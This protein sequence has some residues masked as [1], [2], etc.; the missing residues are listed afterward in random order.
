MIFLLRNKPQKAQVILVL[1]DA[2]IVL[3]GLVSSYNVRIYLFNEGSGLLETLL[4]KISFNFVVVILAHM[5]AF[6]I[7]ELYDT[8]RPFT[9]LRGLLNVSLGTFLASLA[10]A[11]YF[12]FLP[13]GK[14]GRVVVIT[15]IP[16]I[17]WLIF[18]WRKIF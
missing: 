2:I 13:K 14:I 1:G 16:L 9:N 12:Y 3:A 18:L 17:I 5:L 6:Y 11:I 7:F 8:E 4:G 15:Y 10:L